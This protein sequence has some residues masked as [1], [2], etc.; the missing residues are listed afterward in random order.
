VGIGIRGRLA[1]TIVGLVA[2]TVA[3]IGLGVYAFVDASLRTRAIADARQQVDYD[4]SVLLPGADPPPV[5]ISSFRASG[6]PTAFELNGAERFLVD[7]GDGNLVAWPDPG[8]TPQDSAVTIAPDLRAIVARGEIGY[9]WQDVGGEPSLVMGGR[10]GAYPEVYFVFS[11][12]PLESV[13]IQLRLGLLAGAAA[14]IGVALLVAGMI[15]RWLLHPLADAGRAARRIAAGD[16][17][18]RIPERGHDEVGRMVADFNRMAD[19]LE[20]TIARL[21]ASQQQNRLFVADVAHELRTPVTALV[22]EASLLEDRIGALPE[23]SR[24]PAELLVADIRR[25]RL[26][27]EDL[28]EISR[29]DAGGESPSSEPVDLGRIVTGAVAARLPGAAVALPD[30]PVV[31]ESDP[32]RLDRI[33]GNLLDNAREHAPGAAVEVSLQATR[34]GPVIIVADRGPGVSA[35]AVGHLFERFYKADRSR[36]GGSSGLGLAIAAEHAALLGGTLRARARPGGGMIFA[37]SLPVTG[38]LPAGDG[39][40]MAM[41]DDDDRPESVP[42]TG[43]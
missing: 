18:A 32:R 43:P 29:F 23:A 22:A 5:D 16:L 2:I 6:L 39:R 33:L 17:A 13:L 14:A 1:L 12:L 26:L 15:S 9:S 27:V 37:L 8:L 20:R 40:D 31:V 41:R 4:L 21:D 30:R 19:G 38:S 25:L 36:A 34:D 11:A 42:R 10:Q 35:D 28:M 7:F 3:S 24:R